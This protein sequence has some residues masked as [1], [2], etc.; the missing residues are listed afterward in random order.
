MNPARRRLRVLSVDL[1]AASNRAM[2]EA[3]GRGTIL[4]NPPIGEAPA[5]DGRGV[6]RSPRQPPGG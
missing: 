6:L 4:S 3:W 5:A 2:A 1:V